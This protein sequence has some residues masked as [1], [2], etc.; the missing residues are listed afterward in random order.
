[1][2]KF[3]NDWDYHDI[4][5]VGP[6]Y[7]WCN[8]KVGS[9]RI[10]ERLDRCLLNSLALQK[11]HIA[12]VRHLAR[13]ASDHCPIV[14]K[15]FEEDRREARSL[16]F[17]YIW[18]SFKIT[19]H[20]VS[21]I[22]K[23]NF[24]GDDMEVLNKKC[25]RTLNELFYWSNNKLNDFS[26]EKTRL[27][28]EILLLQDE[29]ASKGW[30]EDDKLW[31]LRNKVKE[32]NTIL[33]Y[34]NTWWKQR[35]KVKWV[36]DGDSNTKFFHAFANARRNA[37]W[38][39]QVKNQEGQITEDPREVEDVFLNFFQ[40]KGKERHCTLDNWP[41]PLKILND[42]DKTWLKKEITTN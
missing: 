15:L 17:E 4:G 34:L 8:N 23:K 5:T 39:S 12:F 22:W 26:S 1:M 31:I 14:L 36:V 32:F 30:L 6:R 20:L 3:M 13:V 28:A 38:I 27:K 25:K 24:V 35:A 10:L 29:E 41:N 2:L 21:K 7:T 19:V 42:D 37:N 33:N 18:L 9:G 11:I 40:E 16:R